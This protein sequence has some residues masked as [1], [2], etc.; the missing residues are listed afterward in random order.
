[1][2]ATL[3]AQLLQQYAVPDFAETERLCQLA[4]ADADQGTR[5]L[6]I[7]VLGLIRL[8]RGEPAEARSFLQRAVAM[9]S[10]TSDFS[11][12]LGI[13]LFRLGLEEDAMACFHQAI[14]TGSIATR[15]VPRWLE[16][17]EGGFILDLGFTVDR[18]Y[19][20]NAVIRLPEG[21]VRSGIAG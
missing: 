1:M 19:A 15:P 17:E 11:H 20:D 16:T 7:Y 8:E 13:A 6:A 4:L 21:I 9:S 10:L 12:N 2:P 3:S 5:L 18:A 14:V